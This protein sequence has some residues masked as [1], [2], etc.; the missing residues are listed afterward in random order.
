MC[1]ALIILKAPKV[2]Y[3]LAIYELAEMHSLLKWECG[4]QPLPS[5]LHNAEENRNI[6]TFRKSAV[7]SLMLTENSKLSSDRIVDS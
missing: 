5:T 3:I 6:R 4:S 7:E 1:I 2:H